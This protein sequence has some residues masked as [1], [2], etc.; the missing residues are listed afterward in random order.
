MT[1][2]SPLSKKVICCRV[3]TIPEVANKLD[4][5]ARNLGAEPKHHRLRV[6][7]L[8]KQLPTSVLQSPLF[9]RF[10]QT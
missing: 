7:K 9:E 4:I 1:T 2:V 6:R 5:E 10:A 3:G 8:L